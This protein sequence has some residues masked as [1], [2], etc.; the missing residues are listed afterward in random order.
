MVPP[1]AEVGIVA[2][3][4]YYTTP[5]NIAM[6]KGLA[7]SQ[8]AYP[9]GS[10]F[11]QVSSPQYGAVS[12]WDPVRGAFTYTPANGW[13]GVDSFQY[14]VCLPAPNASVCDVAVE[15]IV[16]SPQN[17]QIAAVDDHY[18]T[19]MNTPMTHGAA[20]ARDTY[21]PGSIFQQV[22]NPQ[23]GV[24]SWNADGT[25]TYTPPQGWIGT[26]S[27]QYLVCLPAPNG[28]MC[29]LATEYITV[30]PLAP[31]KPIPTLGEWGRIIMIF[32]MLMAMGGY[33]VRQQRSGRH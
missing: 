32:M 11:K 15:Y 21:A 17:G 14:L 3:D 4:D 31:V 5:M 6:P 23:H 30:N 22:S 7:T 25:F 12:G 16:V 9:P 18:T 13:S 20:G 19:P 28:N 33:G 29:A 10:T 8:D 26:D 24:V 1:P 27:F 2:T